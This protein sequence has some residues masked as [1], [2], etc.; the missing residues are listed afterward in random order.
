MSFNPIAHFNRWYR[1]AFAAA[2]P[3]P[4]AMA[5][6]T[7]D[8]RGRPS[9]RYVLLKQA[10]DDGFVFYTHFTSRKGREL[11]ANPYA[12]LAFY[13]DALGRQVRV[14]GR[15][16]RVRDAEADAY[17]ATRPRDSQLA[18]AVSQQ[19]QAIASHAD[20]LQR[21]RQLRRELGGHEIPR[22]ATWGGFRLV[23]RQVEFWTRG[24][25]RLHRR[26]VYTRSRAGWKRVL[27]QP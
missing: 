9:V 22:P 7:A 25:P 20:L 4:D 15:V 18:G 3:L 8:S 14:D 24:E 6:A 17:W 16:R 2:V 10:D 1:E 11:L 21:W 5:L 27:L 13:W 19:S 23:P 26:E 12:S